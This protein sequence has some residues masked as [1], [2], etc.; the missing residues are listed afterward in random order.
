MRKP[1]ELLPAFRRALFTMVKIPATTGQAADV[2]ATPTYIH[3]QRERLLE[4]TILQ[5]P[6]M[7]HLPAKFPFL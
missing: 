3:I 2:P 5:L 1:R 6:E 7:G 4:L